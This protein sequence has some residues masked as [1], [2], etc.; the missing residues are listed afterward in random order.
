MAEGR[1]ERRL[2]AI[3]AADV[4]SYSR[5]MGTDEEGTLARLKTYR[6]E[7]IDPKIAEHRGR[8]V[9]TTGDGTLVEF[10]SA[11]DAVRCAMEIQR[12]VADRNAD[13]S[14]DRRIEFRIG[15]NVG[16]IISDGGDIFGDGVNIAARIENLAGPGTIC[17][18]DNAYRQIKGKLPVEVN[19]MGEQVLKN[20]A[21]PVRVYSL[22]PL[23]E[24]GQAAR[25]SLPDKASIAA[26]PF[27]NMSGD[28]E[29]EYFCDGIVEEII[30]GLS[31]IKWVFV[32][33]RNSSFVYKGRAVD[34]KQIGR[35]LGVRYV[36]EGSVRKAGSRVRITAQLIEAETGAHL[37]AERYDRP[38]DD[39]FAVQDEITMCVV[40][41]IEP[42][43]RKAEI[44]RVRRQ[45]PSNVNAYD[46]VLRSL[47]FVYALMPQHAENAIPLLRDALKLEPHYGLA[48]A[49]LSWCF[50]VRFNRGGAR[51]A[52]RVVAIRHAHE[53]IAHGGDDA[54]ALAVAAFVIALDEHDAAMALKLFDQA[55]TLSSSNIFA[56][57]GSAVTL[58]WMGNAEK[59]IE[60]AKQALRFSPFDS[61]NFRANSAMSIA[62]FYCGRYAEAV[63]EAR[64]AVGTNP[65]FSI[66]RAVLAAS[67]LRLG[68]VEEARLAARSVL[69]CEPSFKIQTLSNVALEPAVF[70]A[71]SDAW[72]ELGLPE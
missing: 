47:P 20:I 3:L 30:T 55:L 22:S 13:F 51:E 16:D 4:A 44:D 45:R 61:L 1:V 38:F 68:R 17:L 66:S 5:L 56:L 8:I 72:R 18:S 41:A 62:H 29:Q 31:R 52:D 15:I 12:S 27:N 7:L 36:L 33:A 58:A 28:P 69:D 6:R 37:W 70:I 48:H 11:V 2:A 9:K 35:E 32:I 24:A 42:S 23:H 46:L 50:H 39:I 25:L 21:Q 40:G 63:D 10:A 60:R 53:A 57:T 65:F 26:L 19:D 67:L 71:L 64:T 54:T 59:T 14:E 34:I 43:L 49:L